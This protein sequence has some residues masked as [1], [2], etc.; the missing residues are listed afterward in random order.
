MIRKNRMIKIFVSLLVL[1]QLLAFQTSESPEKWLK[2]PDNEKFK[3]EWRKVEALEKKGLPKSA[4]KIVEQIYE[5]A[6]KTNNH[7]Q[8]AKALVYRSK[9]ISQ[10][11]EEAFP[12]IIGQIED[13]IDESKFPLKQILH[14]YA[15]SYYWA[16]FSNNQ[17]RINQRR[18]IPGF[19]S[20][21]ISDWDKMDFRNKMLEQMYLSLENADSLKMVR[22]SDF[23]DIVSKGTQPKN[24]RPGLYD[25]LA[26]RAIQ[27]FGISKNI[28]P[29][30]SDD[31]FLADKKFF[32]PAKKFAKSEF[33]VY[34]SASH[35]FKILKL[36][37]QILSFRL[38]Q[39]NIPAL[40]DVDLA[41]LDYVFINSTFDKK[42]SLYLDALKIIQEKYSGN[43]YVAE[44]IFREAEYYS[45]KTKYYNAL[46]STTFIFKE[47][48]KTAEGLFADI[49]ENF[50]ESHTAEKS[51][52]KLENLRKKELKMNLEKGVIPGQS[53]PCR[54][55]YKNI[56][57]LFYRILKIDTTDY[58]NLIVENRGRNLI[59][60]LINK[61][62]LA[63]EKEMGF[64][65][66]KDLN[67]HSIEFLLKGLP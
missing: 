35:H 62:E 65:F 17:W 52:Y 7:A 23:E 51:L 57:E 30:L 44:V 14:S 54:I 50:S 56:D 59:E 26:H 4:I 16:Y 38:K 10:T 49:I 20:D 63:R 11:E 29:V 24:L 40:I 27:Y 19:Q 58:F 6:K 48:A 41:R 13:E 12:K 18:V 42:D 45:D 33:L 9:F 36:Y 28:S 55:E 66:N 61:S 34:D 46:D 32:A 39:E 25:F 8:I 2:F 47:Y 5:A 31:Q 64:D 37:Q 22:V 15:A 43:N 1:L 53:F 21:D 60:K 67:K 3:S